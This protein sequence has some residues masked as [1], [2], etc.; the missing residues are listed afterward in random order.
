MC[1]VISLLFL[2]NLVFAYITRALKCIICVCVQI[3]E[4]RTGATKQNMEV[5]HVREENKKMVKQMADLRG[6]VTDLE[7]RVGCTPAPNCIKHFHWTIRLFWLIGF[8]VTIVSSG[9][10]CNAKPD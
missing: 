8:D 4:Y 5:T 7:A 10:T 2:H 6:K 1:P 3:Q 9:N